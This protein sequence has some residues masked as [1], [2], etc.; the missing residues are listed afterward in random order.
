[1]S[2]VMGEMELVLISTQL[3][4]IGDSSQLQQFGIEPVVH[5]PGVG[6]NLQGRHLT[7]SFD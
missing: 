1:M 4:G 2:N 6:T 5:L 7:L 3:S